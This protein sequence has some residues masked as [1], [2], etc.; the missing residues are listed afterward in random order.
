MI[1]SEYLNLI[2]A[3]VTAFVIVHFV[4]PSI[5]KIAEIKHLYDSPGERKS[6][7]TAVPNLGGIAIFGAFLIAYC[8]FGHLSAAA[9]L[10][11]IIAAL[12]LVFMLGA[13]DDIVELSH[14]K[15][16]IGQ[17]IAALIITYFADVRLTSMYGVLGIS[18]LP[19]WVSLLFSTITIVFIINAFNLIDG[20]NWLASGV[21]LI[22]AVSFGIWFFIHGYHE[23]A[24]MSAAT[25]GAILS[26]MRYNYTP[27]KIFMGDSG[28]LSIG[29]ISAVLAI[30]F[31][32]KSHLVVY[33]SAS[34]PFHIISGPAFA[35]SVLIIPI[36]D[37]LRAFSLRILKGNSPFVADRNHIH[38]RLIDLGFTHIQS[39]LILMSTNIA[40]IIITY[41]LQFIRNAILIPMIF[42]VAAIMA[43]ILFSFRI[44]D[45]D[46]A[47][48]KKKKK[49]AIPPTHV[50]AESVSPT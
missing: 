44:S 6:H 50:K 17:F 20:I 25:S 10:Q 27:A 43:T 31:I 4:I 14:N 9:E 2:L 37:T 39:S 45:A 19:Y 3:G 18:E 8:L 47:K 49:P 30:V 26:F 32:E 40:F 46:G 35:I 28:S 24:I 12:C 33:S 36:F 13:K 34:L 22:I 15:K 38:H 41:N 5:I 21:T 29:L 23:Y 1:Y 48:N 7:D 42:G 11:Y 16:F